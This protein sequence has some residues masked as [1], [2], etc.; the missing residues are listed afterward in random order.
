MLFWAHCS[1]ILLNSEFAADENVMPYLDMFFRSSNFRNTA[2][3]IVCDESPEEI[4]NANTVFESIS[5]FGIQRLLD[6]QD[7]ESNSV[8]MSLKKFVKNY[9]MLSSSSVVAGIKTS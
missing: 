2:S 6:D 5:A 9:Y 3:V 1:I 8:Y 7:Y 4:F